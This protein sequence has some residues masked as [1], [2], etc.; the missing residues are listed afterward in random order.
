[1]VLGLCLVIKLE[2][3]VVLDIFLIV[4]LDSIVVVPTMFGKLVVV[5][6]PV[7]IGGMFLALDLV[8]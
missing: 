5:G 4:V 7:A 6:L 8:V 2:A 3:V 1:M